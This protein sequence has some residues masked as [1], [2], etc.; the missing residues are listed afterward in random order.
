MQIINCNAQYCK[1]LLLL[2]KENQTIQQINHNEWKIVV[3][4]QINLIYFDAI[5]ISPD[6]IVDCIQKT[7]TKTYSIATSYRF[8][9]E[10]FIVCIW[11]SSKLNAIYKNQ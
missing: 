11:Q 6:L 9:M 5:T 1:E 4:L 7:T 3:Y 10:L 2:Y 8:R